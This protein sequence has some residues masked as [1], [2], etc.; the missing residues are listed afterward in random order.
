[1]S[2]GKIEALDREKLRLNEKGFITNYLV[3][4]PK[5]SEI[6]DDKHREKNQLAYEKYLRSIIVE[7]ES[8]VLSQEI[9]IGA[10][11]ELGMPWEY[12]YHFENWFVDVSAFY[13]LLKKIDLV[14]AVELHVEKEM[15]IKANLW[16]YCGIDVWVNGEKVC[17]IQKPVYK[18]ILKE[19]MQLGLKQGKNLVYIKLQN[20][21]VRDTRSLF[22]IQILENQDQITISLPDME[23]AKPF[24]AIEKWL[25]NVS[26]EGNKLYLKTAPPCKMIFK[27][28]AKTVDFTKR[29]LR[30]T[31]T[32][33][34]KETIIEI[35]ENRPFVSLYAEINGKRLERSFEWMGGSKPVYREPLSIEANTEAIYQEIAACGQITR[36]PTESFSMYPI[37]ARYYTQTV[38]KEDEQEL[39]KS[40]DQ[41]ESRRDCSDF[42][43]CAFMRL[44]KEYPLDQKLAQRAKEVFLNYRYWMD[45][46][47][48]DGMCFWSENHALMFY[49]S[50]MI[51]GQLYPED[52]FVRSGKKGKEVYAIAKQR[53]EQWLDDVVELGYDEFMS[54]GYTPITFAA[55]LNVVDYGEDKLSQ[56]AKQAAD[57]LLETLALH[58]FSGVSI[59]PMGRVYRE[60]LYP[61]AQDIQSLVHLVDSTKP[62]HF[63]EWIIFLATSK[64]KVKPHL[65]QLMDTPIQTE[66]TTGNAL[67]KIEKT[68]AYMLTSVQS[69]REDTTKRAWENIFLDE[70]ADQGTY[71][72]TKSL[73]ECFHGTTLFEPGVFGYQQHMWYAALDAQ[74]VAFVNHPGGSTESSSM[75]PGYWYG[76]GCMPAVKQVEGMIGSIY[77][78]PDDHPISFTHL[79]MPKEKYDEVLKE[80]NWLIGRKG[81]A[82][83]AIW[84]SEEMIPWNNQIFESEYR[85]YNEATAYLCIV[86]DNQ[87][88]QGLYSFIKECKGLSPTF[89]KQTLELFVQEHPLLRYEKKEN[90][91]QYI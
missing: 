84:C 59:A 57:L 7:K 72:Y 74:A 86:G 39:Y 17:H 16:T 18:P 33:I 44:M 73:N 28:D 36:T 41:I 67:V 88:S 91:T 21:G 63:S 25:A 77:V 51:A 53:I 14:A 15:S 71:A 69:P 6:Q 79:F 8:K 75:R 12:Y 56:K 46:D 34:E 3:S 9:K 5:L 83:L 19:E 22:G 80:E 82:Y 24:V 64:Y 87:S 40:L 37:L 58:T 45:E 62:K 66:Y 30:Y 35:E 1:M 76:N 68:K 49:S 52:L 13:P 81:D 48:A 31:E 47:G 32:E 29:H 23:G 20:L 43:I 11:S 38:T 2:D 89:N 65:K 42:L 26:L 61:F 78:I 50:A 55:I 60:V 4:G 10:L 70:K 90:L 27:T 85:V 54:G